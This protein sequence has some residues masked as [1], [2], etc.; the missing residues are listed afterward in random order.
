MSKRTLF[1]IGAELSRIHDWVDDYDP[2]DPDDGLEEA[3]ILQAWFETVAEEEEIKLDAY[4]SL[5]MQ[6]TMEQH[7]A[8][9]EAREWLRKAAGRERRVKWLKTRLM[10]HLVAT[11]RTEAL[12]ASGRKVAVQNDGG[13]L[14]LVIEDTVA[15]DAIPRH[16]VVLTEAI[17]NV[18]VRA[19]LESGQELPFAKLA[20]RGQHLRIR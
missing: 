15:M 19:A 17:D 12:T 16:Y 8:Q 1:D 10:Q 7:A 11:G 4:C 13:L 5:I 14:P 20:P 9:A 18:K 3:D 2:N 6:L